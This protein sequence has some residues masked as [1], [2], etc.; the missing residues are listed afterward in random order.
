MDFSFRGAN[1]DLFENNTYTKG[2]NM[3]H[4]SSALNLAAVL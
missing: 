2:Q 4:T 1:M 3:L